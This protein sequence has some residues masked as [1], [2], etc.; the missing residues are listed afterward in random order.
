MHKTVSSRL[1]AHFNVDGGHLKRYLSRKPIIT[2]SFCEDLILHDQILIPTQDYLTA[3]GLILTIGERGFIEII[4]RGML[5]FIRTRGGFGFISGKGTGEIGIFGD[6]NHKKP[7]DAPLEKSVEAGL[8]VIEDRIKDKKKLL[9]IIIQNSISIEW[10]KILKA[11]KREAVQDL[12]YTNLWKPEY[13][14]NNPD[15]IVFPVKNKIQVRVIGPGHDPMKNIED[16][17]LALTLYNSD[18]Y[19][20]EKYECENTSPFYPVGDLLEIKK[21]RIFKTTGYS[22]KFWSLLEINGV[23]DLSQIDLSQG[24]NFR[25][26]LDIVAKKNASDFR[27]WFHTNSA[28]SEK[29][30]LREYLIILKQ[31]PWIQRLPSKALRFIITSGLGFI[32]GLGQAITFFDSFIVDRLFRDKSPKFFIDDLTSVTGSIKLQQSLS[33]DR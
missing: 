4:E 15:F 27:D 5:K 25:D 3:C 19:L 10:S 33:A 14:S 30:I 9:E 28:S 2:K 12:K 20:A 7:L 17:L 31:I 13:E 11:V 29:E 8:K 1:T 24:S 32:P 18:L 6:P 26:I 21:N 16:A 23:P 22:G